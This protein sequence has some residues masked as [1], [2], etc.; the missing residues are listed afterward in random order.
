MPRWTPQDDRVAPETLRTRWRTAF[1]AAEAALRSARHVL[2]PDE[3]RV[4]SQRLATERES[5]AGLLHAYAGLVATAPS[6]RLPLSPREAQRLLGLPTE[7]AA[8]VVNLDGV[9]VGSAA[10]DQRVYWTPAVGRHEIVVA[11]DAGRKARRTLIV[12]RG[13]SQRPR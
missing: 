1:E 13:A 10:A 11:D 6:F 8:C 9:L 2:P 7:V 4:R 12:E 5:T 3:L